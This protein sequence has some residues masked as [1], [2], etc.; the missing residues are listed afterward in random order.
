MNDGLGRVFFTTEHTE[1]TEKIKMI[2][3]RQEEGGSVKSL[4]S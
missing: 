2:Q 3:D 4:Q 1:T